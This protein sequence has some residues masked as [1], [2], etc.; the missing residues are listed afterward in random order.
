MIYQTY[1]D[2]AC[3]QEV[4]QFCSDKVNPD[5]FNSEDPSID[6]NLKNLLCQLNNLSEKE[7]NDNVNIPDCKYRDVSYVP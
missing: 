5:N 1:Y 3:I 4:L 6:S 7:N 2:K